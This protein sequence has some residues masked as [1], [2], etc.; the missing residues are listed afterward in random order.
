MSLIDKGRVLCLAVHESR[1]GRPS[2]LIIPES[3]QMGNR[4]TGIVLAD[5]PEHGYGFGD[6]VELGRWHGPWFFR[7]LQDN[8]IEGEDAVYAG[9]RGQGVLIHKDDRLTTPKANDILLVIQRRGQP[10][11]LEAPSGRVIV[12]LDARDDLGHGLILV[13]IDREFS[14][15]GRVMSV[16]HGVEDIAEGDRVSLDEFPGTVLECAD[17]KKLMSVKIEKVQAVI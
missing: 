9:P 1:I 14:Q 3:C 8:G 17:G 16:G 11:R 7:P 5:Y 6:I 15:S 2:G 10:A 12:E 4:W 13:E